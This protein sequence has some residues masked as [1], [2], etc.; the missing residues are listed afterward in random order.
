[1]FRWK[2]PLKRLE[3]LP[4]KCSALRFLGKA[5]H[6]SKFDNQR[7]SAAVFFLLKSV[8]KSAQS[9][10]VFSNAFLEKSKTYLDV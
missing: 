10:H 2:I 1:M 8:Q 7:A 4:P 5:E 6:F 9:A 3:K